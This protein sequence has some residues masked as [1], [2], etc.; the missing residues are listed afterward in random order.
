MGTTFHTAG[1]IRPARLTAL[2]ALVFAA[3]T[4]S[5][6]ISPALRVVSATPAPDFDALFQRTNGWIGADGN[7]SVPV[8]DKRTLWFFSD[9]WLG[10]VAH[11]HR[12]N[13]TLINNSIGVQTGRGAAARVDFFWKSNEQHRPAAFLSPLDG[14]GW[15][16]PVGGAM[17][18]GRLSLLLW[19][20][21]K[22]PGPAA[23]GF[24]HAG[25]WLGEVDNPLDPP[26]RWRVTQTK[27]PF[28]E[29]S[30]NRHFILGAAVL[31]QRDFL[32][33]FGTEDRPATKG[34]GRRMVLARAPSDAPGD[35]ARWRFFRDGEWVND[36]RR[37]TPLAPGMASEYSVT[38]LADGGFVAVTH[39]AFLSP[40]IV[41]R[42]APHPWGPW[43]DTVAVFQC[44]EAGWKKGNFCY[45]GKAHPALSSGD[46]LMITYA[47]NAGSLKDVLH[48]ARLY[49]PRF[50][51]ARV[52]SVAPPAT[53]P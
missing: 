44:P 15:F 53:T 1:L 42:T 23:F 21:E 49:W 3:S 8:T 26:P 38:P 45:A 4:A 16:W 14:R 5:A 24:R 32:Y 39:D 47:A 18:G 37:A 7:Y 29:I 46:E 30:T 17:T 2:L 19:Q 20:M 34:F 31:A 35:F 33:V 12:T 43:S 28:T 11:G 50:V 36:F 13:A 25:V 9:T 52:A 10:T 6:A 22:A 40:R 27:L 48:D 41:A 51:R